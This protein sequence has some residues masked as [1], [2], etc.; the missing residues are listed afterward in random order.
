MKVFLCEFFFFSNG[1]SEIVAQLFATTV[2]D[3]EDNFNKFRE[4][5]ISQSSNLK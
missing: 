5:N 3:L 2:I 1:T 4:D